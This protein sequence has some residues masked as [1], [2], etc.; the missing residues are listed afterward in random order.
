MLACRDATRDRGRAQRRHAA[1]GGRAPCRRA[2]GGGQ[3]SHCM[4]RSPPAPPTGLP[5]LPPA[6]RAPAWPHRGSARRSC[7]GSAWGSSVCLRV[8]PHHSRAL[9]VITTS[10]AAG[11][12]ARCGRAGF[13]RRPRRRPE[14]APPCARCLWRLPWPSSSLCPPSL[15]YLA[16][17]MEVLDCSGPSVNQ[18]QAHARISQIMPW[19]SPGPAPAAPAWPASLP[20]SPRL[21]CPHLTGARPA[22][23][24]GAVRQQG[25]A[26]AAVGRFAA[27]LG[28]RA[29]PPGKPL[30]HLSGAGRADCADTACTLQPRPPPQSTTGGARGASPHLAR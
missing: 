14:L 13:S 18:V 5:W 24:C 9:A 11:G 29:E 21:A 12:W 16:L 10:A 7:W 23:S 27:E 2:G 28:K 15:P 19:A 22:Q 17:Y 20:A 1:T 30:R 25:L 26:A 6:D 3:P 4:G 8:S